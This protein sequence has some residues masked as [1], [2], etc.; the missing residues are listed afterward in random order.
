MLI[1]LYHSRSYIK[2]RMLKLMLAYSSF[3]SIKG[4]SMLELIL[5]IAVGAIIMLGTI[6]A[7]VLISKQYERISAFAEVQEMGI[8]SI[9]ILSRDLR[10]A[11]YKALDSDLEST[12]G[13]IT[14]PITIT[15]SGDACCD[16][17]AI[18]YDRDTTTR[19]RYTYHVEARTNPS[20]NALYVDI[21]NWDGA[22]WTATTSDALVADYIEDMQL[23]GSDLDSSGNPRIV[24]VFFVFR[25]RSKLVQ[26]VSY[27][28]PSET[29]GNY[30][31]SFTDKY[32]RDEFSA[33]INIRNLR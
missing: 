29:I 3:A 10:M 33:T 14:T 4:Y 24:D 28:K 11:G 15:D 31:F 21:E 22:A 8:P 18:I 23:S 26:D 19:E 16:S 1:K 27:S 9:R 6:A 5:A 25:S 20:R 2:Q 32:Y 12:Y 7:N 13:A 30:N 17:V